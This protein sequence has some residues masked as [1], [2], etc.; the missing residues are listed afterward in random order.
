MS[1]FDALPAAWVGYAIDKG[2]EVIKVCPHCA[3][4]PQAIQLCKS[5]K[6]RTIDRPCVEHYQVQ[7]NRVAP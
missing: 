7:A 6:I 3:S 4:R 5:M 1:I 2:E